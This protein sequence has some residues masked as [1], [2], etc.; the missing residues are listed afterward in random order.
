VF[1]FVGEGAKKGEFQSRNPELTASML[2]GMVLQPATLRATGRLKG[3]MSDRTDEVT[4]ACLRV[5]KAGKG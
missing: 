2:L 5:L 1:D 4:E 3:R